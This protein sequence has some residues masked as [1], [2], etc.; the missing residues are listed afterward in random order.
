MGDEWAGKSIAD[1]QKR[2]QAEQDRLAEQQRLEQE[3]LAE[4]QRKAEQVRRS[5]SEVAQ[6]AGCGLDWDQPVEED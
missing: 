6:V 2:L 1:I 3:R 5:R 4:Q